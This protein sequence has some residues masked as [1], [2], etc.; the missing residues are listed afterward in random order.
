MQAG[1]GICPFDS[2]H[3]YT[4]KKLEGKQFRVTTYNLLADY[5]ADSDY[6]RKEL[7]PYCPMYALNIDYRKQLFIKELAG[8]QSDIMCLQEVDSK[9]FLF[10]LEPFFAEKSYSGYFKKKG[11]TAEGLAT[12]YD[13][14]R[15]E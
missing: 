11:T 14:Q 5:Y 9:I 7:F 10:D 12:F 2:R 3:L 8:Y 6:S 13:N 15:F 4:E 1:P